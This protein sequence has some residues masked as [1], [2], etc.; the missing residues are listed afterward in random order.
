MLSPMFWLSFLGVF[1][2]LAWL[3]DAVLSLSELD[4]RKVRRPAS[5]PRLVKVSVPESAF[6]SDWKKAA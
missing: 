6:R 2:I 5:K 3:S 4:V 1:L